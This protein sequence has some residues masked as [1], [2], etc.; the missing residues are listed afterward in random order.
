[1]SFLLSSL[2]Q[3]AYL[4][5]ADTQLPKSGQAMFTCFPVMGLADL[6]L[7]AWNRFLEVEA[8]STGEKHHLN[9]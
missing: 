1:M 4:Q 2:T 9:L 3:V 8:L 7:K 6:H 5:Q